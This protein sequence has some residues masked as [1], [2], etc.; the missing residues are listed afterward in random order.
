MSCY[1]PLARSL[2]RESYGS[3]SCPESPQGEHKLRPNAANI[4]SAPNVRVTVKTFVGLIWLG[5]HEGKTTGLGLKH[6]RG[7]RYLWEHRVAR[8]AYACICGGARV[9]PC[10]SKDI[11]IRTCGQKD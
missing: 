2:A 7:T 10:V 5:Q 3:V 8:S 9:S 4:L 1:W 11:I 6:L